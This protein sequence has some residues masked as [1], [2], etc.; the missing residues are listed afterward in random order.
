MAWGESE[1]AAQEWLTAV[2]QEYQS[3]TGELQTVISP[4]RQFLM[5]RYSHI[6]SV[7]DLN[8]ALLNLA[9]VTGQEALDATPSP[10]CR[11]PPPPSDA[12][13]SADPDAGVEGDDEEV[14]RILREA[15]EG[16]RDAGPLAPTDAATHV[17]GGRVN[18][19]PPRV[20]R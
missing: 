17:D 15:Q 7:L 19:A 12:G 2:L 20:R 1:Q 8:N 4:L 16:A 10:A 9:V 3:G 6:Q 5:T 14:Q 13:A 11:L 18:P